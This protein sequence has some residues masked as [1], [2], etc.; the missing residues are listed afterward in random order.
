MRHRWVGLV[1]LAAAVG[2]GVLNGR[3]ASTATAQGSPLPAA[4]GPEA[5]EAQ[6]RAIA[7]A[8]DAFL[9]SLSPD[10]KKAVQFGFTVQ[11]AATRASFKPAFMGGPGPGAPPPPRGGR[12]LDGA[13]MGLPEG[14][15]GEQYGKA[16]WSNY[17]VGDVPRPG[18]RLGSLTATQRAA[19]MRLLQAALSAEGYRKV[20]DIMGADQALHDT[21]TPFASGR[22]A[23]TLA[24]FGAPSPTAPWMVEFGGHHLALN[25]V[26]AGR[27][28]SI[29]PTLTG[30]QPAVYKEN[31]KTIRVLARES[32]KA[33]ALLDALDANQRKQAILGYRV[34]DLV[35][36][37]GHDGETI[38]PEGLKASTMTPRQQ[39]M[40]LDL[41]AE[42][43]GIIAGP[44]VNERMAEIKAG[45]N[46]TWF[47]W[48]GSTS[49]A[50][51]QNGSAYYRIQGPKLLIEFS[52]Q[53][54][55]GDLT[56]HV[57]TIYRDPTNN[58][59]RAFTRP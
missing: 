16:V 41:I 15:V 8:A 46:E 1:V 58:Y 18:L 48:S 26:M 49:H 13:P 57:H 37:P 39:A 36:G 6:S 53:G 43:A 55:G 23:Y 59:G 10:Q 52:P 20:L 19:A 24:I 14:F 9:A 54:V 29:T 45:L 32:D 38:A 50:P 27:N 28:G 44:Y 56:M 5:R 47:A 17:P 42:W 25:L 31:G 11:P 12:P 3:L 4:S 51:D 34:G 21:G 40:L 22:D 30:A 35:L 7:Q 33:F 2:A